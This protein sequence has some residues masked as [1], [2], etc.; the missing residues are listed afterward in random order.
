MRKES[1]PSSDEQRYG[2]RCDRF[3]LRGGALEL[4]VREHR[5]ALERQLAVKL[6]PRAT[7]AVLVT[8]LDGHG[9]RDAVRAQQNHVE[10]M[11]PFPG[12]PLGCV[13]ARPYV[14][15]RQRI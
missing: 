12:Q 5:G 1:R 11:A 2:V 3:D 6:D 10:G 15:R 8:D 13:V 7:A 14:V 9:P 4:V